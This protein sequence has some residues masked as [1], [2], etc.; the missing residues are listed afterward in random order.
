MTQESKNNSV[1]IDEFKLNFKL[2]S[3]ILLVGPDGS[4][5]TQFVS[6]QLMLQLKLAQTGRKKISISHVSLDQINYE[7]VDN[8][9]LKKDSFDFIRISNQA[10]NILFNK[11]RNLTSYPVNFDFVIVDSTGFNESIRTEILKIAEDNHYNVSVLVFNYD[12]KAE[13]FKIDETGIKQRPDPVQMKEMKRL[14]S[15]NLSK[16]D[17]SSFHSITSRDFDKYQ[18]LVDDYIL[19]DQYMLSDDKEYVVIGDIHGCLEEFKALLQINGFEIGSDNKVSHPLG[20]EVVL[21]GDIIDKGYD[22]KGVIDFIYDNIG[23]FNIVIGN[24]EN[25]VYRVLSGGLKKGDLPS[26]EVIDKYFNS[27]EI[28]NSDEE[29][30]FKFFELFKTM[31]SFFVHKNFIVTHVSCENKF[32]G[33]I[34]KAALKAGRDFRVPKVEEFNNFAEFMYDFDERIN[35]IRD[36]ASDFYPLH[37][38]GHVE[39]KEISRYKNKINIDTACVVGGFLSS[40]LINKKGLISSKLIQAGNKTK[41]EEEISFNFFY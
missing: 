15:G 30:K 37:V 25:F 36:E 4:G 24:H 28:L 7:L 32:L 10:N 39:T 31:K 9:E 3:I 2:H 20:T 8:P 26:K 29:L 11:I 5:K 34:S 13:Y 1:V 22:I 18:I 27:I 12:N 38:F 16:K 21:V 40:I 6:E 17:F 33:K 35:F 19:Y 23:F 14:M 41:K